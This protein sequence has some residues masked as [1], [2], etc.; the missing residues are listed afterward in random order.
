MK[1]SKLGFFWKSLMGC[2]HWAGC[3]FYVTLRD[4]HMEAADRPGILCGEDTSARLS[5]ERPSWPACLPG[6][7]PLGETLGNRTRDSIF[8]GDT[9]EE[10]S[11]AWAGGVGTE[12]KAASSEARG[13]RRSQPSL[14][15]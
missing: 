6:L 15:L 12:G 8:L 11:T 9:W 2:W 7:V 13:S 14:G 1:I 4:K 10:K 5:Q 3:I